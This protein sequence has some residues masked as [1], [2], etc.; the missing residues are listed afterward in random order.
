MPSLALSKTTVRVDLA[1]SS[2]FQMK[3]CEEVDSKQQVYDRKMVKPL[4]YQ[5]SIGF[6]SI[7]LSVDS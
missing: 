2:Y 4:R 7:G 5:A 6:S 3:Q 1:K